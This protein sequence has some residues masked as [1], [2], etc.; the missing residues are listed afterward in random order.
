MGLDKY[1]P[2]LYVI[3]EDDADRQ[4]ADGFVNDLRVKNV[5]QVM[6]LAGGWKKV[7]KEIVDVYIPILRKYKEL[8][9]VGVIDCD[10]RENRILTELKEIPVDVRKRVFIL[11]TLITPEEFKASVG[12]HFAP[13]GEKLAQECFDENFE[14]WNHEHLIFL[15]NEVNRAKEELRPILFDLD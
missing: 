1:K 8:R 6:P 9:V 14:L 4:I 7:I 5:V 10:G 13:L 2:G 3:P 15:E 12:L 11:G